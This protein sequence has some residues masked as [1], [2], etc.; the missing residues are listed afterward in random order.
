VPLFSSSPGPIGEAFGQIHPR[1]HDEILGSVPVPSIRVT[2]VEDIPTGSTIATCVSTTGVRAGGRASDIPRTSP[3]TAT[4][5][6]VKVAIAIRSQLSVQPEIASAGGV[7][8]PPI[9]PA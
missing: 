9:D 4:S 3:V 6:A 5:P 2:R 1:G 8:R 7:F